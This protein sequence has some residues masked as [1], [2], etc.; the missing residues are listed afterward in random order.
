MNGLM[1]EVVEDHIRSHVLVPLTDPESSQ[2]VAASE[3]I[4]VVRSYLR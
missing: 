2:G 1:S 4:D 3:L